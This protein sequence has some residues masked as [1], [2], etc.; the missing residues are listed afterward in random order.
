MAEIKPGMLTEENGKPS[1][2]RIMAFVII[3]LNLLAAGIIVA[4]NAK[5]APLEP[6]QIPDIPLG[7]AGLAGALMGWNQIKAGMKK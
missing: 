6:L 1:S 7:W 4:I 3:F 2:S 5:V